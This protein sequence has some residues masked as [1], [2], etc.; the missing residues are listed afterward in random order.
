MPMIEF[1]ESLGAYT[2]TGPGGREWSITHTRAGWRMEFWDTGDV[3]PTY[4]GMHRTLEAA[5]AEASR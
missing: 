2:G 5:Q 3:K 1:V 4:A